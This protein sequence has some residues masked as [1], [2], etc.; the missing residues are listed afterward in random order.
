MLTLL[1]IGFAIF[2]SPNMTAV[3]GSVASQHYGVASSF[4]ATMRTVGM[5][6]SMTIITVTF[7]RFMGTDQVGPETQGLFLESMNVAMTIFCTMSVM[8]VFC[9]MFRISS[10][11]KTKEQEDGEMNKTRSSLRDIKTTDPLPNKLSR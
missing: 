6:T 5:L 8:G 10:K 4:V 1:G 11:G 7:S 9:S 2:S 3:M